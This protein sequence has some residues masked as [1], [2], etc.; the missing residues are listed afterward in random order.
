MNQAELFNRQFYCIPVHNGRAEKAEG[1][2]A[3]AYTAGSVV[4]GWLL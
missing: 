4:G 1:R 3:I 2:R